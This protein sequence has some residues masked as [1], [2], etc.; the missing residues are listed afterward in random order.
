MFNRKFSSNIRKKKRMITSAIILLVVFLSIGYAAFTTNLGINGTLNVSKYDRTLYGVL[1]KSATVGTYAKE[2]TRSHQDSM[3]GIGDKKIYHW[4]ASKDKNGTA[5]TDMNNV[6]FAEHCWKMIRT[7][8]TGGVKMVYNGEPENGECL[9]TR[10]NH[11]GYGSRTTQYLSETY[12]YGTSYTYDKTNNVFSL[13]GTITTGTIQTGQY[14][15]KQTT[16]TGTCSTL[17][18][19]DKVSNGTAYYVLSLNGNSHYSQFGTLQFNQQSDSPAYVG[20]MYNEVYPYSSKSMITDEFVLSTYS[21]NTTYWYADSV[22]WGTPTANKYNLDNPEQVSSTSDY[23]NLVGKYT[24]RN[25]NQTY[26]GTSVYYIAAVNGNYMYYIQLTN[27]G[28]HTLADFDYSYTYGDSYTDNGNGTYTINNPTTIKRSDWYTNYNNVTNKYVCKNAVNDTC[29]EL[30]YT[31]TASGTY[32]SYIKV[33]DVY[34]YAN[35][36]T[37][38][39]STNTYTLNSDSVSFWNID[40]STNKESINHHHYTCWNETG[41]CSTISYIYYHRSPNSF[42]YIN[43]TNGKSIDDAKNEMLYNE[44]VNQTN[45]VIKTGIDAWYK[46]YIVDYT[47]QLEDT[48]F[49]NDRSQYN[50]STNGW[51]P[52]G[53][54]VTTNMLFTNY[55]LYGVL[56][57]ANIGD[58]FSLNNSKARLIYPVS[59]LSFPEVYILN[60]Y[61]IKITGQ[62]YWLISPLDV[63]IDSTQERDVYETGS[64]S[65]GTVNTTIGVRP[66][67]SLKPGTEYTSGTGS[68]ADPYVVDV[69]M[70]TLTINYR[71]D[72]GVTLHES[73]VVTLPIG[74]SFSYKN[75]VISG[76]Q[77]GNEYA[78]G[79]I[80]GPISYQ[81]VIYIASP[82]NPPIIDG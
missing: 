31:T 67:I 8:D 63:F 16:S 73:L 20:Y 70:G 50:Q 78:T 13:D 38:N 35:D 21:L 40:D 61:K 39:S 82:D 27:D 29:N 14:T 37:Y 53:G 58:K 3:A 41:E 48:I 47:S 80:N 68:M 25:T 66:A 51:N 18:L 34:K 71:S 76:Y 4:W 74:A 10:G 32:M 11:V 77:T 15:C 49:C 17:Y 12:Y 33:S 2:Y 75:P 22:T 55:N 69:P 24:F 60:N 23:S 46:R 52:N 54:N 56:S 62:S 30:L 7:T 19:V 28:N 45:S 81:E 59:L 43:I 9:N 36:F 6:L 72:T 26:T 57:C 64:D 42:Y 1:E 44:N 5:I 65:G 79:T